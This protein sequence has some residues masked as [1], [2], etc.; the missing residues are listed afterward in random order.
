M[1]NTTFE[2]VLEMTSNERIWFLERLAKQREL[3]D[4][5]AKK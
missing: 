4:R 3:E 1:P 2:D 5:Q